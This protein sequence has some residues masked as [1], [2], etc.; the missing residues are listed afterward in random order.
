MKKKMGKQ[1]I[2]KVHAIL[3]DVVRASGSSQDFEPTV[4]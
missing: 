4:R 3:C 2:R 1:Y